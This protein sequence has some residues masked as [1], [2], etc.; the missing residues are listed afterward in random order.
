MII[1]KFEQLK[2][3][4]K[5]IYSKL[6]YRNIESRNK[7][8]EII[9][10]KKL[11]HN[12]DEDI[13]DF[14]LYSINYYDNLNNFILFGLNKNESYKYFSN[15]FNNDYSLYGIK[16]IHIKSTMII[17][18][19]YQLLFPRMI[20]KTK[21]ELIEYL[22]NTYPFLAN[23]DKEYIDITILV[24]RKKDN[25]KKYLSSDIIHDNHIVYI[26]NTKESIWI[27]ASLFFSNE[28]LK[29][30]EL[31]NFDYFL[32]KDM[33]KSKKMFLK[34]RS[35]LN[36]N[37][38]YKDQMQ[39]M[40]F[41][42]IVLY[43]IGN[44]SM[45][46]LDLYIH[47][48][49]PE[50]IELTDELKDPIFNYIEYKIKNTENWPDYWNSWLD[51]W[52]NKCGAKYFEEILANPRYHFYFL[53]VKIIS[54]ECDI[55]R[56]IERARPRAI[57]DLIALRKRYPISISIPS[58]KEN[59]TKFIPI[60]DKTQE[61]INKLIHEGGILNEE[62]KEISIEIKHDIPKTIQTI[63]YALRER[64]RMT[65]TE[66]EI[67]RELNMDN[68]IKISHLSDSFRRIKIA[69]KKKI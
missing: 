49:P 56:R 4:I 66:T 54:L 43:L 64:Y 8:N 25:N 41:S 27:S 65:F 68:E 7:I 5:E 6:D 17:K 29:F 57:A 28:S 38:L 20:I 58:L 15:V 40:L 34:Y 32:T 13:D 60:K 2:I 47:T 53:G 37:I 45:N 1:D 39:F 19:M 10:K 30:I 24:V 9:A 21:H 35:W 14:I 42:S 52:A 51:T 50:I 33:D 48:L 46:D 44:R 26:P 12:F 69:I 11:I 22:N 63:I 31:Q 61:E 62:N 16:H 67:L 36:S 18:I 23:Y 59:I 55:I 3:P